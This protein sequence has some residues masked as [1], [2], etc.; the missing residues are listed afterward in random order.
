MK[1]CV[2]KPINY[3]KVKETLRKKK[4]SLY[5][6]TEAFRKQDSRA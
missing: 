6:F 1:K 3:N 2:L 5:Q 4:T